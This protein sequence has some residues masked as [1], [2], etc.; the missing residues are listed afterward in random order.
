M[1]EKKKTSLTT[2]YR[3]A[4]WSLV[5]FCFLLQ[6]GPFAVYGTIALIQSSVVVEKVALCSTLFIV[7]IMTII[8]L[9]NKMVLR[10]RIWILLIGLYFC[11]DYIL[12]P[13]MIVAAC[14][15]V[16]ELVATPLKKH[17]KQK[18]TISKEI[19]KRV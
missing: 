16:D 14:Q 15:I 7:L 13:L 5:V 12:V 19:D 4:F 6:V 3:I 2:K 17:F 9:I 18:L 1:E 8:C 11:L 10:S